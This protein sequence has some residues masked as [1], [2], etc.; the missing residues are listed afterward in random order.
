MAV[1]STYL[2]VPLFSLWLKGYSL[3]YSGDREARELYNFL[4]SEG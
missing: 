1:N 2:C 4:V 3:F